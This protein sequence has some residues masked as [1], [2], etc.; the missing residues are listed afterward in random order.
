MS[1]LGCHEVARCQDCL[2]FHAPAITG[3]N[4]VN[5]LTGGNAI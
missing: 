4:I 5:R 3:N 1:K 2:P